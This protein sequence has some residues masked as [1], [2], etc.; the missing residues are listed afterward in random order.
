[1]EGH[2]GRQSTSRA[3]EQIHFFSH[4]SKKVSSIPYDLFLYSHIN[5]SLD[6]FLQPMDMSRGFPSYPGLHLQAIDPNVGDITDPP[7]P[8]VENDDEDN[9][10]GSSENTISVLGPQRG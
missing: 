3:S 6:D 2:R 5:L 10:E 9:E 4:P 8:S 1:M 7:P